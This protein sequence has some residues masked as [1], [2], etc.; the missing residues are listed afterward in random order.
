MDTHIVYVH[1]AFSSGKSFTRIQEKLPAHHAYFVEYTMDTDLEQVV[2]KINAA[3]KTIGKPVSIISHSLG[4]VL[5][6]AASHMNPLIDN[7]L[8]IAT[9]FGGCKAADMMRWFNHHIMFDAISTKGPVIRKNLG[10]PISC[11][12][13]S[14]VTSKGGNPMFFEANDGVVTVASQ[15]ALKGPEY[16]HLN[17]NHSEILMTDEAVEIARSFIFV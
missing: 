12:V 11:T 10:K 1:G 8:T 2:A 6:V 5:S 9:P 17:F 4:G 3:V 13:K 15:V 14:I 16:V 7:V